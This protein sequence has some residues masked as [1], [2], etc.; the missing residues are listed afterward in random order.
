MAQTLPMQTR[1]IRVTVRSWWCQLV[2]MQK[3]KHRMHSMSA[4]TEKEA[5]SMSA[6][7]EGDGDDI[8]V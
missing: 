1:A 4:P 6:M 5:L 7:D 2:S 8:H 3:R